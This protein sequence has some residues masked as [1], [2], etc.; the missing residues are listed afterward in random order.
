MGKELGLLVLMVILSIISLTIFIPNSDAAEFSVN[1][2]TQLKG[3]SRET[4]IRFK[5]ARP[6]KDT[7]GIFLKFN[8]KTVTVNLIMKNEGLSISISSNDIDTGKT[9]TFTAHDSKIVEKLLSRVS[10]QNIYNQKIRKMFLRTLN[11]LSSWPIGLPV[12]AEIAGDSIKTNKNVGRSDEVYSKNYLT[13]A[14]DWP[15]SFDLSESLCSSFNQ[16]QEGEILIGIE[17]G[18]YWTG[19]YNPLFPIL[20]PLFCVTF[21]KEVGPFPFELGDCF[22]R[23]GKGCIGDGPPNNDL[24]IFTQNCFNHDGCVE[25]LGLIHPWCNQMFLY[26]IPDFFLGSDC[27]P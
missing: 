3:Y 25:V 22:G 8:R 21:Q 27:S 5:A 7:I 15:P 10:K 1:S 4:G 12:Y 18:Y 6:A 20:F 2:P 16:E 14:C 13:G 17:T 23:C 11:L 26:A 24:N 9:A 19:S